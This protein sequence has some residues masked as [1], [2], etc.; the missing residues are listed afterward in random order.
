MSNVK[1]Q[2]ARVQVILWEMGGHGGPP[3]WEMHGHGGPPLWE[4]HGQRSFG[5]KTVTPGSPT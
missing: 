5:S 2:M 4:M 1:W 3:L